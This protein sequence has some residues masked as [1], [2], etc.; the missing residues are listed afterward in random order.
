MTIVRRAT[1][2]ARLP[3]FAALKHRDY[4]MMWTA[5][6]FS[7]AAMWSFI[8]AASWLV[9]DRSDTSGWV[10]IITFSS[11]LPFLLVSPIAGLMADRFDRRKLALIV[12]I[13]STINSS[14]LAV[15][16]LGGALELWHVAILSFS[17]G[18]FR[19][20]QEPVMMALIPNQVPK[21]DL[22]NAITL[23]SATRH[24]AKLVLLV[25]SPLL[26][27]DFVGVNG[28]LALSAVFYASGSFQMSRVRTVSRGESQ[29]Q[30]GSVR[31]ILDGLVH[32]YTHR[33]IALFVILVAFHCA[34]TMSFDSLLPILSR[35]TLGAQD[36]AILGY[37][38]LGFGVGALVGT[39]LIAGIRSEQRKGQ[40]LLWTAVSSGFTPMLLALSVNLPMAVLAA[41][42]MGASMAP[43]MALTSAYVQSLA[44]D[45]LR[46][47]IASLYMLHAGG[48]MAFTNLS[49]GFLADAVSAP[50]ILFIAGVVFIVALFGLSIGQPVLRQVYRTG[51]PAVA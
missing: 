51:Q 3:H 27:L 4:R 20:A 15:L 25:V 10:G 45:R 32:I 13:A 47:R 34:L 2:I 18:V 35:E 46:G 5:N 31:G 14:L 21:D 11:M 24:G 43:F 33:A 16:A 48:I 12:F 44:P 30:H 29:P 6:L 23:N 1:A 42:G 49:Y 39:L 26:A 37:L 28:V 9:L 36:G 19:A 22:L 17:G 8:V 7:G 50:P 40:L 38:V 41:A